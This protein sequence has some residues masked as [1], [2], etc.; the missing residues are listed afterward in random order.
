MPMAKSAPGSRAGTIVWCSMA[1]VRS[2]CRPRRACARAEA[3]FRNFGLDGRRSADR[4]RRGA[5]G[6]PTGEQAAPQE[7]ALEW[8]V[9]MHAAAAEARDLARRVDIDERLPVGL[10]HACG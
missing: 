10:Q 6:D 8:A 4:P 5:A 9:A 1:T 7:S 2:I 3:S